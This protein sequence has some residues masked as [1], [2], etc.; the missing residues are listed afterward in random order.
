MTVN[1]SN[2]GWLTNYLEYRKT[3]FQNFLED[4]ANDSHPEQSM[5]RL[6]RPS[7]MMYGHPI[8]DK[9]EQ[10]LTRL[11]KLK[12]LLAESLI[13]GSLIYHHQEINSEDDFSD[14]VMRT[15][16][17]IGDFYNKVYPEL[18]V[19]NRTF[20]GKKKSPLEIAEKI[21]EKRVLQT[22]SHHEN[23]WVAFFDN[24]ILFLDIYFFGRWMHTSSEKTIAEFFMQEKEELRFSIVKVMAAAA[25]ANKSIEEEE[26]AL[27]DFFLKSSHLLASQKAEAKR[28]FEKGVN[29][30]DIYLPSHNSWLLKKFFL[31]LAILT[32]WVDRKLEES[33]MVFL[34]EFTKKLG[35]YDEDLEISLLAVEGF[36][37]ENW[38]QLRDLQSG[39][40][41]DELGS[42]YLQRIKLTTDRNAIQINNKLNSD[43]ELTK[44]LMKSKDKE[45]TREEEK[46]L[47]D[48]LIDVLK[49]VPTFVVIGLPTSYLTLPM[50]LK[51]LP[52]DL[53]NK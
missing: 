11:N 40:A 44:L 22:E 2:R 50:L 5:Y 45:L 35:F 27:F 49:A 41:L 25:H 37:L 48:G 4:T 29:L 46:V 31:E 53:Q 8:A 36:I 34:R 12:L 39:H 21:L 13:S 47:H 20:L 52:N 26:Q 14:V 19:S 1:P 30:S 15:V 38:D 10:N 3:I 9:E 18:S 32:A 6:L 24:I 16:H 33:E 23:F 43:T 7:G 51:I 17:N 28:S 42:E